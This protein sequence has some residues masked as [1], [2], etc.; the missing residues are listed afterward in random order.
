M[1][2]RFGALFRYDV[3]IFIEGGL[4]GLLF[5]Q[6][7]RQ[8]IGLLYSRVAS[9][10]LI[11]A[12]PANLLPTDVTAYASPEQVSLEITLLG[13]VLALP[14]LMV[15]LGRIRW[16]LVISVIGIGIGRLLL[17]GQVITSMVASEI[18][19]GFGLAYIALLIRWR[20]RVLPYFMVIGFG[21]E[22]ILRAFGNTI[23]ISLSSAWGTIVLITVIALI[24]LSVWNS[25]QYGRLQREDAVITK[26]KGIISFGGGLG[27]G[28]LLFLQLSLFAMP[29]AISGRADSDYAI[30]APILIFATT[31]PLIPWVRVQARKLIAPFDSNTRGWIWY[32]FL[33]LMVV[34]GTRLQRLGIG[35]LGSFPI[36]GF[37]LILGAWG[38]TMLWWWFARPKAERD[39]DL[40]GLWVTFG[41]ILFGLL[42]F[43]D[44]FTY[45]YAFVRDFAAPL[46]FL[47]GVIPPLLRGFRGMGLGVL[48]IGLLVACLPMIQSTQR[49]P[50]VNGRGYTSLFMTLMV[51]GFTGLTWYLARPPLVQ[52]TTNV[53]EMRVGT[54]NIHSGYS[55]FFMQE[56]EG[57]A[58]AIQESGVSVVML[59]EV[60]GGRLTS[61]GVDQSLWLARRLNMD[62]RFFPTNEGLHGLAV[63]SS[64]PIVFDDGVFLDSVDQQTGLQRVQVLPDERAITLYNTTLGLLLQGNSIEEQESNQREQLNQ[65]L[66]VIDGH[67]RNDYGGR[68]E[69]VLMVLGGT[70]H[71]VPDSP[72]LQTL[73]RTGFSDPFAGSNIDLTSTLIRTDRKGRIDYLWI[74]RQGLRWTGNGVI[75][76]NDASDHRLAFVNLQFGRPQP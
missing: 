64:A 37:A 14:V 11:E 72:L 9:A 15:L 62:R 18:I 43:A 3:L 20:M 2:E 28:A 59:Q 30:F 39:T 8:L 74:W 65:I 53:N 19:V 67:I 10:S 33:A 44:L 29:N 25:L 26:D 61:F 12:Y 63:L 57:M 66:S 54:Y 31:I 24:L 35:G 49:V 52:G 68:P 34:I 40:S 13:V 76:D 5:I 47:N 16:M 46:D 17:D 69:N 21:L 36:G 1:R 48:L 71:N 70:F 75:L 45:E 23:D 7:L 6:G 56:L 51:I 55:E 27:I 4:I 41:S 32:I 73:E 42:V 50:W 38:S 58:L 22:Q 60:D